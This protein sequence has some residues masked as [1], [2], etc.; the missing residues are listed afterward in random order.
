M[1]YWLGF[2]SWTL[3]LEFQNYWD[4]V[5]MHIGSIWFHVWTW[6]IPCLSGWEME[7]NP[8]EEVFG[9]PKSL[10]RGMIG[11]SNTYPQNIWKA[12][13]NSPS[14]K[15]CFK[16]CFSLSVFPHHPPQINSWTN[17]CGFWLL[18]SCLFKY[19]RI[20][21]DLILWRISHQPYLPAA[22]DV[23]DILRNIIPNILYLWE[24]IILTAQLQKQ[25][26]SQKKG[27]N[28]KS[29][30]YKSFRTTSTKTDKHHTPPFS[31]KPPGCQLFGS[32]QRPGCSNPTG[33]AC[34]CSRAM[35]S[36]SSWGGGLG[37]GNV[38]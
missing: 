18:E 6:I 17:K 23:F 2:S 13:G 11:G 27:W 16:L 1:E 30:N 21:Q 35:F 5:K 26:P 12:R 7:H 8:S 31:Q 22:V 19:F 34:P 28:K 15:K 38:W 24:E 14:Q 32:K 10:L 3:P 29:T 9:T 25:N 4:Q 33:F 20:S 37:T 36:R